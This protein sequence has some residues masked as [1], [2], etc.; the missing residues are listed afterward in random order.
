[1]RSI[2]L[3]IPLPRLKTNSRSAARSVEMGARVTWWLGVL[4]ALL[5]LGG[6][7]T[8]GAAGGPYPAFAEHEG[9]QVR[10]VNLLGDLRVPEDS[11]H[12]VVTI[13]PSRCR[14]L[15]LPICLPLFDI[16]R[17]EYRL[18]LGDLA[19]DVARLE[20]YHRDHG[21]YGALIQ[22]TLESSDEDWVSVD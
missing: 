4:V 9:K 11:L 21:Y 2:H 3:R 7:A 15:F 20:L 18:D 6:C 1:D 16:G 13:R 5:V 17:E 22:P 19:T 10:R 12:A 14:F 8:G